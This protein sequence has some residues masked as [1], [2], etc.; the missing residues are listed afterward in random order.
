M[1]AA[2]SD[3]TPEPPV[4]TQKQLVIQSKRHRLLPGLPT[5]PPQSLL[6]QIQAVALGIVFVAIAIIITIYDFNP[7]AH[8]SLKVGDIA[9][10]D[11]RAPYAISY[12][13]DILTEQAIKR[14]VQAVPEVF[15]PPSARVAR[16]QVDKVRDIIHF[17]DIVRSDQY[18]TPADKMAMLKAISSLN[19]SDAQIQ[20]IL[21]LTPQQWKRDSS[22]II[23][24]LNT[25]MA[26]EIREGTVATTRQRIPLLISTY[27]P[28]REALVIGDIAGQLIRANTFRDE[29]QTEL[30]RQKARNAVKP[31]KV[32]YKPGEIIIRQGERISA[33][34][35]EALQKYGLLQDHFTTTR[36]ISI[37]TLILLIAV[38]LGLHLHKYVPQYRQDST[39]QWALFLLMTFYVIVIKWIVP[40]H[41]VLP[42]L[43]PLGALAIA[44]RQTV[45]PS[46]GILSAVLLAL[47]AGYLSGGSLE[48]TSY[49][50]LGSAAAVY[51]FDRG[52]RF[53]AFIWAGAAAF[54]AEMATILAFFF[55]PGHWHDLT[56]LLQLSIAAIVN[57]GL[58]ASV[59]L[60]TFYV[61][62]LL[63]HVTTTVQL[64]ELAR[65][66]HPLQ[67]ALLM[68]APGTYHHSLLVANMTER[69]A[70]AVGTDGFLLRVG[71][72]YH[73]I[74][75]T[76]HPQYFVENQ[77]SDISPH[78]Q[79]DPYSSARI[80]ISHVV[81]DGV[82]L[83]RKYHLPPRIQDFIRE[84]HGTTQ[85]GYFYQ[86]AREQAE[87]PD[88]V[89][90][91]DFT[92][93]GPRPRSKETAILML[94]DGV[95]AMVR[96][97]RP[98]SVQE[99]ETSVWEMIHMRM[100]EGQLD[101]AD[102][103][104]KE[105]AMIANVFVQ[106]LQGVHHPRVTYPDE[107]PAPR[108]EQITTAEEQTT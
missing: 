15:N 107:T 47:F 61:L 87:D 71:S 1:T 31:V 7:A 91:S 21:S 108:H 4:E 16:E 5:R 100:D 41:S 56:G 12:D 26:S 103:T 53:S 95:E 57:G 13:S 98:H 60:L 75:K 79:L 24:V 89:D 40:H 42:F 68:K 36:V 67:K 35:L 18:A 58:V 3:S 38:I 72:Y 70:D 99:I 17:I 81:P 23:N 74:G 29:K 92:Y 69:A 2:P 6:K 62:G 25:A 51:V 66:T 59:T 77:V 14:A 64:L 52:D 30:L 28:E 102:L 80:I 11:I 63:L 39:Q 73:D 27:L 65:P 78:E 32:S 37:I 83:A 86:K 76:V 46:T 88:Q 49:L 104:L 19:L 101:N 34:D 84:H 20:T 90:I 54:A 44:I 106:V 45:S 8:L 96:S 50:I 33:A 105:I 10:Q 43:L 48:L 82:E 93:P 94:A 85:V 55:L 22:E 97:R 9:P